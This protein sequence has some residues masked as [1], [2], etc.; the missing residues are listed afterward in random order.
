MLVKIMPKIELKI[1]KSVYGNYGLGFF[2]G[3]A[4]FVPFAMPGDIAFIEIYKAKKDHSFGNIVELLE[5]STN[6][7]T[8]QCPNFG[9]CGG[10]D[11]IHIPYHIE[12]EIKKKFSLNH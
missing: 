7:I 2:E 5:S 4:I 8:P 12:L 3:K 10:C 11:Y 1:E 9:K 6:R